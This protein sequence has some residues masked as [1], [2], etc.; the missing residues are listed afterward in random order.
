MDSVS[1]GSFETM[2]LEELM[3]LDGGEEEYVNAVQLRLDAQLQLLSARPQVLND[4]L[5]V[6]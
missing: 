5:T 6:A 3:T 2:S 1:Y 4:Y